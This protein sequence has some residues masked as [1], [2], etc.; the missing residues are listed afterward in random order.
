MCCL[1]VGRFV[2]RMRMFCAMPNKNGIS[3]EKKHDQNEC[4]IFI[5]NE[6]RRLL[7][8]PARKAKKIGKYV[9]RIFKIDWALRN[10]DVYSLSTTLCTFQQGRNDGI[11][12]ASARHFQIML[13]RPM[14]EKRY[15]SNL[16]G[17][18]T[19]LRANDILFVNF[20]THKHTTTRDEIKK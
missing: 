12:I 11:R 19:H 14:A 2:G 6:V 13:S 7:F 1:C 4:L 20:A 8:V 17:T 10:I 3:T 16:D 9:L 15:I 5:S 18:S